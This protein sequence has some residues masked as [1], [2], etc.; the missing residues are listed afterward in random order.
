MDG[1]HVGHL[2]RRRLLVLQ[3]VGLALVVLLQGRLVAIRRVDA[4][5][6]D[7]YAFELDRSSAWRYGYVPL[8]HGAVLVKSPRTPGAPALRTARFVV[9]LIPA[10]RTRA[11][12]AR[13]PAQ[14]P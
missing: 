8:R 4:W 14:A 5:T 12:P 10:P 6:F 7:R 2:R 13:W 9:P 1:P 3:V 11:R